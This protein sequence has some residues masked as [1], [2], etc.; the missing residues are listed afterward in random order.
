MEVV[1]GTWKERIGGF[2]I[3]LII[4]LLSLII[5]SFIAGLFVSRSPKAVEVMTT[6]E[7]VGT[8]CFAKPEDILTS[9]KSS[10]VGIR[11]ET[12]KRLF[13]QPGV[14][15]IYYDYERDMNYPERAEKADIV[16]INL[17][18]SPEDEA[19]IKFVRIN[20]PVAIVLKVTS[21]GWRPIA[22]FSSWLRFYEYP[23]HNW[24][25]FCETVNPD[26]FDILIR[27][28]SGD[29]SQYLRKIHVFKLVNGS[30]E[31]IAEI[32]EESLKP[33]EIYN[34]KDWSDVR[35]RSRANYKFTPNSNQQT[36]TLDIEHV[37]DLIKYIGTTPEYS[38]WSETDGAWHNS[39]R[40]WSS[41]I[42]V[43]LNSLIIEKSERLIWNEQSHRFTKIIDK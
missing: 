11:R 22:V 41:R 21:C 43:H 14:S 35:H 5:Y 8:D 32:D 9:L 7:K 27:E 38:Y 42:Y 23:Y 2:L 30:F 15:T 37:E 16:Y 39:K 1:M 3:G 31:L 18:D 10:D 25:E 33:S 40:H 17:D 4:G 12:F 20:S 26:E 6:I 28:S 24:I 13:L 29:A 19:V 34:G 36:A